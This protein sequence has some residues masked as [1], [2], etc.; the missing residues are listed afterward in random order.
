MNTGPSNASRCSFFRLSVVGA[1]SLTD[2]FV[3][4]EA[5]VLVLSR[6]PVSSGALEFILA[7]VAVF[8]SVILSAVVLLLVVA[9]PLRKNPKSTIDKV[10]Y[11]TK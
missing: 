8:V 10:E 1:I 2:A 3:S 7:E 6:T 4:G 11:L 9:Q 5:L